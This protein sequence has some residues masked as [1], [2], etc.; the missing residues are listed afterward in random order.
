MTRPKQAARRHGDRRWRRV[1][2]ISNPNAGGKAGLATNGVSREELVALLE[3]YGLGDELCETHSPAEAQ[4]LAREA[5]QAGCDLVVG[6]GGDGTIGTVATQLLRTDATLGVLPLGSVMNIARS[7]GLPRDLAQAVEILATGEVRSIDVGEAKGR[8]FFET[9]SV[10]M[11]AAIF[12]EVQ[13]FEQGD[14]LSIVR[15]LWVAFR[16]RP[17]R[18]ELRLGDR[19]V[20]TRALMVTVSNGPYTGAAMTVAPGARLDDGKFDVRIF[21]RFSKWQLLRHLVSIAFGRRR[22]APEVSTYRSERVAIDSVH[23]LPCRVDSHDLGTTP[24]EFVTLPRVLRVVVPPAERRTAG[25]A[26]PPAD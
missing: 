25:A 16:Y 2:V 15:T 4:A 3:R 1:R 14:W 10:G 7:I 18:M 13:R 23:P 19:I 21:R 12:R 17:A 5:V 24:V 8:P 26:L 22:Y 20:R 9:G 11:N 6:A